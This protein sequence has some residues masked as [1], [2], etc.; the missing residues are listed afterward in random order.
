MLST[1][2]KTIFSSKSLDF[3]KSA[4]ID[5]SK[6]P[7]F[8]IRFPGHITPGNAAADLASEVLESWEEIIVRPSF[9]NFKK[10]LDQ[11]FI[12]ILENTR[13]TPSQRNKI[14][15]TFFNLRFDEALI[16]EWH[17]LIGGSSH[18]CNTLFQDC[19]DRF[20]KHSLAWRTATLFP[21]KAAELD[22]KLTVAEEQTLRYVAG[23]VSFSISKF[24]AR[25]STEV[26]KA[27]L[28]LVQSWKVQKDHGTENTFLAYTNKWVDRVNRGGLYVV[29]DDFY[30]FIRR[31]ENAA[32]TIL[33]RSLMVKYRGEDLREVLMNAFNAS[34]GIDTAWST[35]T[36]CVENEK[37]CALLKQQILKKWISIRARSFL[38]SWTQMVKRKNL[39]ELS[40]KSEPSLR[41]ALFSAKK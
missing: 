34:E 17:G 33:N 27:I 13:I 32:R 7:I 2:H 6:D 16:A 10:S 4:L 12:G 23:Y 29:N 39:H 19:L 14:C 5:A 8:N 40:E 31:V 30:I 35:L 28:Q 18:A 9:T 24:Y 3:L 15:T 1:D 25:K 41:K 26:G 11:R 38:K 20:Y 22:L 37:V 36:R 21:P